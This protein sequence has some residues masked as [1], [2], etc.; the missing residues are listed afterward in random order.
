MLFTKEHFQTS[1]ETAP[2]RSASIGWLLV[3]VGRQVRAGTEADPSS[4]WMASPQAEPLGFV[5]PARKVNTSSR[6]WRGKP[7]QQGSEV[8]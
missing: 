7:A 4:P 2:K 1:L 8:M 6:T 3:R 5:Q